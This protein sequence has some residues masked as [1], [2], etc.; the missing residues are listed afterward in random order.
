MTHGPHK[1]LPLDTGLDP[2]DPL[3]RRT[4]ALLPLVPRRGP[5]GLLLV[6]AVPEAAERPG[7]CCSCGEPLGD[8]SDVRCR[9]CR[10]AAARAIA[11]VREDILA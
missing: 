11:R 2:S 8:D 10:R 6:A 7:L 4:L 5:L 1:T 3:D 9:L